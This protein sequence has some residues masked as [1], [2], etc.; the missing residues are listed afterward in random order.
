MK[1]EKGRGVAEETRG[2]T[3]APRWH[4]GITVESSECVQEERESVLVSCR[5]FGVGL[6]R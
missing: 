6:P 2:T 4:Q 3:W 5:G 1:M